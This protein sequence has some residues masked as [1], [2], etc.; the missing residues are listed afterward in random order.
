MQDALKKLIEDF[1]QIRKEHREVQDTMVKD[2]LRYV[3]TDGF[4]CPQPDF[5]MPDA[6]GL[7][8]DDG[9]QHVRAALEKFLSHPKVVSSLALLS[10]KARRA[11]FQDL[12]V[13]SSEG[14]AYDFHFGYSWHI[15][16]LA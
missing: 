8:S 5:T 10:P 7:Y 9:N 3:I 4:I 1:D 11:A 12:T 6:F 15:K 14:N 13:T 2:V 16:S